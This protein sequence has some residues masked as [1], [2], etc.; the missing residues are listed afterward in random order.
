LGEQLALE[1]AAVDR[2]SSELVAARRSMG[3]MRELGVELARWKSLAES[4]VFNIATS[5]TEEGADDGAGFETLQWQ[6]LGKGQQRK[7]QQQQKNKGQQGSRQGSRHAQGQGQER[8]SA[9]L[10]SESELRHLLVGWQR[11]AAALVPR[12][13]SAEDVL[14]QLQLVDARGGGGGGGGRGG[15]RRRAK[16]VKGDGGDGD[17]GTEGSGGSSGGSNN[18]AISANGWR[19]SSSVLNGSIG[20]RL[21]A[22]L[23][24][25]AGASSTALTHLIAAAAPVPTAND[26][27]AGARADG[28]EGDDEEGWVDELQDGA[29]PVGGRVAELSHHVRAESRWLLVNGQ[30]Q[31]LFSRKHKAGERSAVESAGGPA[32][33]RSS[34]SG[35]GGARGGLVSV[36]P[37]AQSEYR[38]MLAAATGQVNILGQLASGAAN[39]NAITSGFTEH[40]KVSAVRAAAYAAEREELRRI[41]RLTAETAHELRSLVAMSPE[42]KNGLHQ[43]RKLGRRLTVAQAGEAEVRTVLAEKQAAL[44]ALRSQLVGQAKDGEAERARLMKALAKTNHES[45]NRGVQ[46]DGLMRAHDG[47]EVEAGAKVTAA[48]ARAEQVQLELEKW[49]ELYADYFTSCVGHDPVA[50]KVGGLQRR[51]GPDFNFQFI[52]APRR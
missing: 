19:L 13:A 33:G 5:T 2:L 36:Q 1:E 52:S 25:P 21:Q 8:P 32:S 37:E 39:A 16:R 45:L 18:G 22:R 47:D 50:Q 14:R 6:G 29:Q 11:R 43:L 41:V 42:V 24:V 34:G 7:G 12:L 38:R 46:L 9:A 26:D 28:G 35:S 3:V 27:V 10:L 23:Q 31:Q 40:A 49:K 15:V 4:L 44:S 51:F 30:Y 17:R 20:E 48:E